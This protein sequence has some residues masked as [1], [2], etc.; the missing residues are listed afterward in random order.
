ML[1]SFI[2]WLSMSIFKTCPLK[3]LAKELVRRS[4]SVCGAGGGRGV[5]GSAA[6]TGDTIGAATGGAGC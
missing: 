6:F 5:A 2:G 3:K 4:I 1:S